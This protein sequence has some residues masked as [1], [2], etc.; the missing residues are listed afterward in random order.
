MALADDPPQDVG[1]DACAG[2]E[3]V[4]LAML[5]VDEEGAPDLF[6]FQQ[7]EE[8]SGVLRGAVV[9]GEGDDVR[10]GAVEDRPPPEFGA[11]VITF[12]GKEG[13]ANNSRDDISVQGLWKEVIK[14]PGISSSASFL[15]IFFSK[16]K[17]HKSHRPRPVWQCAPQ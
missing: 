4:A 2:V 11:E 9:P 13:V 7:V 6:R 14:R 10:L 3:P 8:G 17:T 15:P 16:Q 12:D 5:A 1:P